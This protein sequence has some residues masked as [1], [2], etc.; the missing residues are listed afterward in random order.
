VVKGMFGMKDLNSLTNLKFY[1]VSIA[2]ITLLMILGVVVVYMRSSYY[3]WGLMLHSLIVII[4]VIVLWSYPTR[5]TNTMKTVIILTGMVYFYLLFILYPETS[6]TLVLICLIPGFSILFFWPLLI[7]L[8][9]G[10]N[11]LMM[12][13]M[14]TYISFFDRGEAFPHIYLDLEGNIINFI[15]SQA[16][17][18]LIFHVSHSRIKKQQFY[19]EQVQQAERLKTAGQLAAAVAHEIRNPITV[20]KGFIQ[21]YLHDKT[22]EK[23]KKKHFLLMLDELKVAETVITDFLSVAKPKDDQESIV[24]VKVAL[25]DVIDLIDSFALLNNVS[26]QLEVDESSIVCT[27]MEFKQLFINLIKNAIEASPSGGVVKVIAKNNRNQVEIV[28]V[29]FGIGMTK[30]EL[31]SIGTLFYSLKKKG[32]GLGLMICNNIVQRFNGTIRFTSEKGIGTTVA[33]TFP[34]IK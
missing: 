8:S 27:K 30:E 1:R 21:L 31:K 18:F 16:I 33:I 23:E 19:F 20:V 32:T 11:L 25:G 3:G 4:L 5:E 24:K 14:F 29:D 12:S 34:L 7:Y 9:I 26:I 15:A 22:L 28:V 10:L 2:I 13:I 17:L 6:S